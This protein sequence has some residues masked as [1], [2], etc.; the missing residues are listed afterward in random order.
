M[1]EDLVPI[2]V[3]IFV[4]CVLPIAVVAIIF[5]SDSNS[6]NQRARVMIEAINHSDKV[7]TDKLIE[8]MK[9]QPMTPRRLLSLRLLR[10][11][12]F[13]LVGLCFM[14]YYFVDPLDSSFLLVGLIL[15]AVGIAYL[16]VYLAT[17]K[18]VLKEGK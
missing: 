14:I 8:S 3:P 15:A 6:E 11:L 7:D 10:G 16:V 17:R 9:K 2:L 1:V 12:I 5:R 18:S 13:F 4:C